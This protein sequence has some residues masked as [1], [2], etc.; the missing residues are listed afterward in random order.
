MVVARVH[1][2]VRL[3]GRGSVVRGRVLVPLELVTKLEQDLR[4]MQQGRLC[5]ARDGGGGRKG[6][7]QIRLILPHMRARAEGSSSDSGGTPLLSH[8]QTLS[9]T[10]WVGPDVQDES[11]YYDN[12]PWEFTWGG[13]AFLPWGGCIE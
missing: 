7:S 3:G 5:T 8:R 12:S 4:R 10:L 9:Q 2:L 6:T 13:G 1:V 11:T